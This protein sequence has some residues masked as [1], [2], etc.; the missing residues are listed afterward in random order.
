[1][2]ILDYITTMAINGKMFNSKLRPYA[3]D[4]ECEVFVLDSET[5]ILIYDAEKVEGPQENKEEKYGM[6][7]IGD[8]LYQGVIKHASTKEELIDDYGKLVSR[9]I[10]NPSSKTGRFLRTIVKDSLKR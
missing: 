10:V 5:N 7:V 9:G 1:M 8:T 2:K 4:P 3:L 6:C